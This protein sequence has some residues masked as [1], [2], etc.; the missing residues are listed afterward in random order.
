MLNMEYFDAND[1]EQSAGAVQVTKK[2]FF[3]KNVA[4][5]KAGFDLINVEIL[6]YQL[7]SDIVNN[8]LEFW[9]VVGFN[10]SFL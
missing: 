10:L 4:L 8:Q 6:Y 1:W 7:N 3:N 9:W 2:F 5:F